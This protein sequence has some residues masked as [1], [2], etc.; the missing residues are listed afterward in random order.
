VV[1]AGHFRV[2]RDD[3]ADFVVSDWAPRP[4]IGT[5][6]CPSYSTR[7]PVGNFALVYDNGP[8]G[9]GPKGHFLVM[10][11]DQVVAQFATPAEAIHWTQSADARV[12][13]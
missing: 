12:A 4:A 1:P 11:G 3:G 7:L 9:Y 5:L 13:A 10:D 6:R 2:T 8:R